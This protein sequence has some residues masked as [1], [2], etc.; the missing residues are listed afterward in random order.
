MILKS[1][2][3]WSERQIYAR[4]A[5]HERVSKLENKLKEEFNT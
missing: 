5:E 1:G 3:N 4:R 2:K